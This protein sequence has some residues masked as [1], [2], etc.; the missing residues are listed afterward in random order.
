MK[1]IIP[2]YEGVYIPQ[3]F[4]ELYSDDFSFGRG[5]SHGYTYKQAIEVLMKGPRND[6]FNFNGYWDA[7]CAV[8][9]GARGKKNRYQKLHHDGDLWF[10]TLSEFRKHFSE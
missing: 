10:G 4:A 9:N 8:L 7:W 6:E 2:D 5:T 3:M 1:L